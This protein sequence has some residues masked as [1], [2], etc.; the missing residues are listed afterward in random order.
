MLRLEASVLQ[1]FDIFYE[2][3]VSAPHPPLPSLCPPQFACH[4]CAVTTYG[5]DW[6]PVI[7]SDVTFV[8]H[9]FAG[10]CR[11]SGLRAAEG[12]IFC[13]Q[14]HWVAP[15]FV[16]ALWP[17]TLLPPPGPSS[18]PFLKSTVL[19]VLVLCSSTDSTAFVYD[20]SNTCSSRS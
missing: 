17:L 8:T 2:A 19:V 3:L 15:F 7:G 4:V 1:Y 5:D 16:M 6:D 14:C 10:C 12:S 20:Y 9:M 13:L 18:A 11:C